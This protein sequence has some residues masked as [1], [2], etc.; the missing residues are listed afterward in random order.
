MQDIIQVD[1]SDRHTLVLTENGTV[2]AFGSNLF[3]RTG[4]GTDL[5]ATDTPTAIDTT[6]LGSTRIAQVSAGGQHSLLLTEDGDVYAFGGNSAGRTGLGTDVG[7]TLIATAIDLTNLGTRVVVQVEAGGWH[8]VLRTDDGSVFTFGY[9][10]F[11]GLGLV[12]TSTSV[13]TMV[14]QV[15]GMDLVASDISAGYQHTLVVATLPEPAEGGLAA[16]LTLA[17][18]GWR[19]QRRAAQ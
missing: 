3:G 10:T 4:L 1:A 12:G 11:N 13:A 17:W 19:G 9:Y 14:P 5:G 16:V 8:S 7:N 6:N 15:D 18:L 2:F